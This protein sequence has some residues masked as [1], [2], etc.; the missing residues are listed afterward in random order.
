MEIRRVLEDQ[1]PHLSF[2][3]P[4]SMSRE[5]SVTT[6]S[7]VAS[8]NSDTRTKSGAVRRT[9]NEDDGIDDDERDPKRFRADVGTGVSV[10]A[11]PECTHQ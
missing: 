11:G 3:E 8:E 5:Q 7:T 9:A 10:A 2:E 6:A 1:L 4:T